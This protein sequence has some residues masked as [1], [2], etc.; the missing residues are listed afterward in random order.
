MMDNRNRRTQRFAMRFE[1]AC[2]L[3][4]WKLLMT[5]SHF[6]GYGRVKE[7]GRW[8]LIYVVFDPHSTHS[9]L[10]RHYARPRQLRRRS[11]NARRMYYSPKA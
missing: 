1:P 10:Q 9:E 8:L 4:V 7:R 11:S 3:I 2:D 5:A 6:S